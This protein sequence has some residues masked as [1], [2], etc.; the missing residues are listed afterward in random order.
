M[1]MGLPGGLVALLRPE[2]EWL[3]SFFGSRSLAHRGPCQG[4]LESRWEDVAWG[5][6]FR[7]GGGGLGCF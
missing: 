4:S 3:L 2:D 1:D 5:R 6:V 7:L